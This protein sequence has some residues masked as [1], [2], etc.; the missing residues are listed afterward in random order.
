M[1][2]LAQLLMTVKCDDNVHDN[3]DNDNDNDNNTTHND[4]LPLIVPM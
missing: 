1:Q 3:S 2:S 4:K